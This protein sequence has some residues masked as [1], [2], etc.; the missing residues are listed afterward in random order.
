MSNKLTRKIGL[1]TV[2]FG[3][4]YGISN[5]TGQTS[6]S[7]VRQILDVFR[8]SGGEIIDTALAYGE[9]EQVLGKAGVKEFKMVSKFMPPSVCGSSVEEQLERSLDKL[10]IQTLYGYLAHRTDDL[11]DHP[12]QWDVLCS[13]KEKN[14]LKKTGVSLT[15]PEQ[16]G[17][18][19]VAGIQPDIIQVPYNYID[20]RFEKIM[21]ECRKYGG[22]VHARSVFLQGL[23]FVNPDELPGFFD[24]I[25]PMLSEIQTNKENLAGRLLSFSLTRPFIDYVITGV[26]TAEQLKTNFRSVGKD[27]ALPD[28]QT[29]YSEEILNPAQ[30]PTL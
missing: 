18:L 21:I 4:T 3:L 12:E 1:G 17:K 7:E 29:R 8:E 9:S 10:G 13:K 16:W 5:Q 14:M 22:E 25:K 28:L 15:D 30:W 23:F 19:S 20:R 26:E 24:T 6:P 11:I 2:Q 27:P